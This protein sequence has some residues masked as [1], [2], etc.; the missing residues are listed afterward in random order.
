MARHAAKEK[1]G[2]GARVEKLRKERGWTQDVLADKMFLK[3]EALK[4]KELG[5]R[6]FTL[7]EACKLAKLF[8]VTLDYLV[9]GVSTK[10][11]DIHERLG[12]TDE[13]IEALETYNMLDDGKRMEVL[14]HLFSYNEV[15]DSL[16]EYMTFHPDREG[17]FRTR[18]DDSKS[19]LIHTMV[20]P[21]LYEDQLQ[22]I[23]MR[24]IRLAKYGKHPSWFYST[25]EVY[26]ASEENE[27]MIIAKPSKTKD[28]KKS[29][30]KK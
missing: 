7:E 15:L 8:N 14:S 24:V 18:A 20:S 26:L 16:Y 21:E 9:N 29:T 4:N 1:E 12:L 30:R 28:A 3:R 5:L 10:N 23:L 19:P 17:Y 11:V 27:K 25:L 6:D 13:G 2:I 22:T